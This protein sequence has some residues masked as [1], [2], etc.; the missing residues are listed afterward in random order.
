MQ[1]LF[2]GNNILHLLPY[3]KCFFRAGCKS[4]PAVIVR[5]S[6]WGL[7]RCNSGTDGDSPDE[8]RGRTVVCRYCYDSYICPEVIQGF[9]YMETKD[10]EYMNRARILADRGRG[11]VNPNPLVGAVIVKDGR[12]IGE[13]WHERYGGLHAERNAFKQCTE[14]PAGATLYVTLEPCCHYGKTPPCT[15]LLL[16][17][18]LPVLSSGYWIRI[19]W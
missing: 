17:T 8:R 2:F 18:G 12:I 13:G 10:R 9:F 3:L 5:D 15:R 4:L 6:L 7:S 14:D 19:P 1:P 11:W 16:K